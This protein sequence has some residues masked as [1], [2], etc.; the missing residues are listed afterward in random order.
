MQGKWRDAFGSFLPALLY[1]DWQDRRRGDTARI[2][3]RWGYLRRPTERGKLIWL[4]CGDDD[5]SIELG[6]ALTA[7][8]LD[9]RHDLQLVLTVE[10]A[11]P[12]I[13][14]R[15]QGLARAAW[16]YATS[17]RRAALSRAFE[18]LDPFAL[19]FCAVAPRP[20]MAQMASRA[21][22]VVAVAPPSGRELPGLEMAYPATSAQQRTWQAHRQSARAD[23]ATLLVEAQVDPNF[24]T[25]VNG[26]HARH[27]WWLH[28]SDARRAAEFAQQFRQYFADDVLFVSGAWPQTETSIS[29]WN[30]SVLAPGSIVAVDDEKWL[31]A[32]AASVTATHFESPS[33]RVLWQALAGGAPVTHDARAQLPSAELA[34]VVAAAAT[35]DDVLSAWQLYRADPILQRKY[36]DAARRAFWDERR[37]AARVNEELLARVFAW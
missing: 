14:A 10:R 9:R 21:K 36:A 8:I 3:A 4:Q 13:D 27:L 23:M 1:A 18:R 29:R 15:L 37:R 25:L 33:P 2:A 19:I 16:G 34:D 7:A 17:D 6:C 35:H 26:P 31:P 11:T 22:H 24:I 28:S 30:R 12:F 20:N 32:I 5:D